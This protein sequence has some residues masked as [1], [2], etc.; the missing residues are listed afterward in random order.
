M[1]PC[2]SVFVCV[3]IS[4]WHYHSWRLFY[5]LCLFSSVWHCLCLCSCMFVSL[6]ISVCSLVVNTD[7]RSSWCPTNSVKALK[8][9]AAIKQQHFFLLTVIC[10]VLQL[11]R[12]QKENH[13]PRL[14]SSFAVSF[15]IPVFAPVTM[16]TLPSILH[17]PLYTAPLL[18][19]LK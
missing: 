14:T 13:R 10:Y 7:I 6:Y 19:R 17:F 8:A 4:V 1:V 3:Y 16:T 11:T 12:A 2:L 5:L 15:P 18:N 9:I